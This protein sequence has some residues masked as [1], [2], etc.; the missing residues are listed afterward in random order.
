MSSNSESTGMGVVVGILL[1]V[2]IGVVGY[3]FLAPAAQPD[4]SISTP[5]GNISA[6]IKD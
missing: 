5:A 1:A 4:I 6:D 3:Y 2:F